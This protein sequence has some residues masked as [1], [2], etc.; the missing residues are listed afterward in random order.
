L[1]AKCNIKLR[2]RSE[3]NIENNGEFF[4][5]GLTAGHRADINTRKAWSIEIEV[6]A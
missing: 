6:K 3:T 1:S 2:R 4:V 5:I